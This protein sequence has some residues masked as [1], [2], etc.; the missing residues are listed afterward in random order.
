MLQKL[1]SCLNAS[2]LAMWIKPD[3]NKILKGYNIK[4]GFV[5]VAWGITQSKDTIK[6]CISDVRLSGFT[7][8]W[9][10]SLLFKGNKK[11][12]SDKL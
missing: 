8:I 5:Q 12:S 7:H 4:E 3:K 10:K 6:C 2:G 1:S 9:V 11:W